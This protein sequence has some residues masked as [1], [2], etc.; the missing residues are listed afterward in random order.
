LS[1]GTRRFDAESQRRV[2]NATVMMERQQV[3][4]E[5]LSF[6]FN[7]SNPHLFQVHSTKSLTSYRTA[8]VGREYHPTSGLAHRRVFSCLCQARMLAFSQVDGQG[9]NGARSSGFP[10]AGRV[11]TVVLNEHLLSK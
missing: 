10:R 11:V 8:E 5:E 3:K 9:G 6:F 1:Q 2:T 4:F 7:R